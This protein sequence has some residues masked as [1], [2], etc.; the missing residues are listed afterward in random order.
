MQFV[1]GEN[2]VFSAGFPREASVLHDVSIKQCMLPERLLDVMVIWT[3]ILLNMSSNSLSSKVCSL[4]GFRAAG[5]DVHPGISPTLYVSN[6]VCSNW[7]SIHGYS[8]GSTTGCP[9]MDT[10]IRICC[11][12]SI[13]GYSYKDPPWAVHSWIQL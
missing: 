1:C 8:Y 10:V 6:N 11:R 5:C 2:A 9:C 3:S 7:L 12:L 13:H 4:K